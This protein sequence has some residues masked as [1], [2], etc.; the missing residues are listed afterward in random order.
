MRSDSSQEPSKLDDSIMQNY[1]KCQQRLKH[2]QTIEMNTR[3]LQSGSSLTYVKI[4]PPCTDQ[5]CDVIFLALRLRFHASPFSSSD[6]SKT[7][8]KNN[9]KMEFYWTMNN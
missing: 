1:R 6:V 9:I 3:L 8:K 4:L 2:A 7:S 5:C